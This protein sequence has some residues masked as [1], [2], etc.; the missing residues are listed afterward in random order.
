MD[1]EFY[2]KMTSSYLENLS[3]TILTKY[4]LENILIA[5]RVGRVFP[6]DCIVVTFVAGQCTGKNL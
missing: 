5:H 2:P 1:L 6:G 3:K 4:K